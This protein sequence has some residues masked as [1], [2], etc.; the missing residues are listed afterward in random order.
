MTFSVISPIL[1]IQAVAAAEFTERSAF[2]GNINTLPEVVEFLKNE[3]A[4]EISIHGDFQN[5]ETC[6][7]ADIIVDV[8][9]RL[10]KEVNGYND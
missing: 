4:N 6:R 10:E 1:C 3:F 5:P 9:S 7:L 8:F 2:M